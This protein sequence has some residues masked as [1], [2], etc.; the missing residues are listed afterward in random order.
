MARRFR[1]LIDLVNWFTPRWTWTDAPRSPSWR[2]IWWVVV[3][4]LIIA[5]LFVG[6]WLA[7]GS[8]YAPYENGF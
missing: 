1:W 4:F 7:R 2:D 6:Y 8:E 3:T 5:A